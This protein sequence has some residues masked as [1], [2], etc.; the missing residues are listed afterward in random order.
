ML[1]FFDV[2][3]WLTEPRYWLASSLHADEAKQAEI[4]KIRTGLEESGIARAIVTHKLALGYDWNVGNEKLL[5]SKLRRDADNLFHAFLLAPDV[6][7]RFDLE[8][9]VDMAYRNGVRLF[10]LF[11]KAHFYYLNDAYMKKVLRTLADRRFPV[12]LDLKQLDVTGN[13]YFDIDVL[14]RVLG[15]NGDL[16]FILEASLKQ[17]MFSRYFFP[18]LE[19]FP[20]L[21]LEISG[22]I[23]VD[24]IEGYV[25]RYGARRL[26][27][28]TNTP[29]Q[30]AGVTTNRLI[31]S[32]IDEHDKE[33]IASGNLD[34]ILEGIRHA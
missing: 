1:R 9:Y 17:C 8:E 15:E 27:F 12:M 16:P 19:A 4:R 30:P 32:D 25:E 2:N 28:G 14:E 5:A 33:R 7:W 31:L 6:H 11:P 24:Q 10:R 18:L 26:V 3:C 22:L 29:T 23:L 34:A 21:Y 20:N 13:K